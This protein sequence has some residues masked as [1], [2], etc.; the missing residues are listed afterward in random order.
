MD[1]AGFGPSIDDL[2][3]NEDIIGVIPFCIVD[4]NVKVTILK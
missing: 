1:R 4:E 3:L 2:N